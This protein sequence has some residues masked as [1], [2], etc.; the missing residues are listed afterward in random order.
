MV[1]GIYFVDLYY[2]NLITITMSRQ[3]KKFT[4]TERVSALEKV[5]FKLTLE[6]QSILR[7]LNAEVA[8]ETKEE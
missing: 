2:I 1:D 4:A 3:I 7:A 6:V 8:E 5:V